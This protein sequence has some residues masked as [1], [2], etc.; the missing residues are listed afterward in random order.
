MFKRVDLF[1]SPLESLSAEWLYLTRTHGSHRSLFVLMH[2]PV[3]EKVIRLLKFSCQA[4]EGSK[5]QGV[6]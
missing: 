2:S 6:F 1:L 4:A 3:R 5:P